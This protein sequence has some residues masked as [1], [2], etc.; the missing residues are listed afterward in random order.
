MAVKIHNKFKGGHVPMALACHAVPGRQQ[1]PPPVGMRHL[2][3]HARHHPLVFCVGNHT[4]ENY[5]SLC[6]IIQGITTR[7]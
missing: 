1:K 3:I 6:D 7:G 5:V 4:L 2:Q